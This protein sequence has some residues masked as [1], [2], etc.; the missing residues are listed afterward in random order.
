MCEQ[1][2]RMHYLWR[3]L[4]QNHDSLYFETTTHY[5]CLHYNILMKFVSWHGGEI[6]VYNDT[7]HEMIWLSVTEKNDHA[8]YFPNAPRT[9]SLFHFL[10]C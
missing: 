6:A 10:N 4:I 1:D 5:S 3:E 7:Q 9:V 2:P 8:T